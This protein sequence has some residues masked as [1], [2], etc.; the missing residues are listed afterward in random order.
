VAP[1]GALA[2]DDT[3]IKVQG[4]Q[5]RVKRSEELTVLRFGRLATAA[6]TDAGAS[7][8]GHAVDGRAIPP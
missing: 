2:V 7:P 5:V 4:Y 1:A 6:H 8:L 3:P